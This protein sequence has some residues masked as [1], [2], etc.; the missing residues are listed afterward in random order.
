M[1]NIASWFIIC[2]PLSLIARMSGVISDRLVHR[3]L[4]LLPDQAERPGPAD[5]DAVEPRR[6]APLG[7]QHHRRGGPA[8][9]GLGLGRAARRR[10]DRPGNAEREL[11]PARRARLELR[12]RG[13]AER[14]ADADRARPLARHFGAARAGPRQ[15][16]DRR[17]SAS[18][19]ASSASP[20]VQ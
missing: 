18:S 9:L 14:L 20:P 5:P 16:V 19:K 15:H 12:P 4:P 10:G 6:A 11:D 2:T 8:F 13:H 17:T 7:P 3:Q 1:P